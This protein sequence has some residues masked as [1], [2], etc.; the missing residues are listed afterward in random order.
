MMANNDHET[1]KR[2]VMLFTKL[3]NTWL[4]SSVLGSMGGG[5]DICCFTVAK[6][7]CSTMNGKNDWLHVD[8]LI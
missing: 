7:K 1:L 6:L 2:N 4:K 8:S 5:G 3:A